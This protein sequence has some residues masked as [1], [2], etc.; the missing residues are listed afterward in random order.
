MNTVEVMQNEIAGT[1]QNK[2]DHI[3]YQIELSIG[4]MRYFVELLILSRK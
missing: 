1:V 4:K 3:L 2:H